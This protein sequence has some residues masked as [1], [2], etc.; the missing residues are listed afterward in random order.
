MG[1]NIMQRI[2]P[3]MVD[4]GY[5]IIHL[6]WISFIGNFITTR[7]ETHQRCALVQM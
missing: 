2:C 1:F 6:D 3:Y 5:I 4:V 7:W